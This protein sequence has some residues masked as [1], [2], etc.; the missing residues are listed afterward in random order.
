MTTKS[1]ED[2]PIVPAQITGIPFD[3]ARFDGLLEDAGLDAVLVTSKH[4][5]QYML[6]GYRFFF[7]ANMDAHGLSR[8][9]A[10]P[11]L[12][13]GSFAGDDLYWQPYGGL[14]ARTRQVLGGQYAFRQHDL[15][16]DGRDRSSDAEALR[17]A[18]KA[19]R[20]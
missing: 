15:V 7:Y 3:A 16:P 6:G 10:L 20:D 17:A 5:I 9:P 13:Q 4:N 8:Y 19:H 11:R 18:R 12:R 14:R 2:Q 1:I